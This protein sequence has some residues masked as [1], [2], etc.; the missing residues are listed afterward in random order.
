MAYFLPRNRGIESA[1][2]K[3][4]DNI[5]L[6]GTLDGLEGRDDIQ[7]DYDRLGICACA[8]LMRFN[9]AKCK[10][11]HVGQSSPRTNTGW[12]ENASRTALRKRMLIDKQLNMTQKCVLADQKA[13]CV[14]GCTKRSVASR[15]RE[16]IHPLYSTSDTYVFKQLQVMKEGA[17][18]QVL[19]EIVLANANKQCKAAILSLSMELAPTLDD[20]L[21]HKSLDNSKE[22]SNPGNKTKSPHDLVTWGHG[23]AY[24]STPSGPK[25]VPAKWVKPFI[26]KRAKP[27]A[28]APQVA[29]AAWRRRKH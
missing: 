13:N 27:P 16:V 24:V 8:N 3:A 7:R 11:L 15:S 19:E 20:M 6:C 22:S 10:A 18:E 29:S 1:F 5:K 25:W 9:W 2:S 17:Q 28:E 14:L 23:Y 26:P 21:Q 4:A 12:V